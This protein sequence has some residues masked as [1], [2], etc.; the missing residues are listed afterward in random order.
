M[1]TVAFIFII[2]IFLFTACTEQTNEVQLSNLSDQNMKILPENPGS[3]DIIKLVIY[4]DCTY[5]VL[6]E[7]KKVDHAITI[8]KKF[9][10]MMKWPCVMQND[11]ILV[12]VFPEGSY[13]VNYKL[14]DLSTQVAD[15]NVLSFY[16]S[17]LVSK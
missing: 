14:V 2:F 10:S 4:G 9:N 5:N 6:S 15:P 16:F 8:T 7:I 12:G 1:K 3:D 11:T 13:T 17:L